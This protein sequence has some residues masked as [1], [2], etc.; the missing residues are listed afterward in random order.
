MASVP[1]NNLITFSRG[2][3]ATLTGSNG[4]IQYAPNNFV[5]F[6]EQFDNAAW[7]KNSS[8]IATNS[9]TAPDGTRTAD[10]WTPTSNGIASSVRL[11]GT[12]TL[13]VGPTATT[14]IYV[15]SAGKRWVYM[16]T[17]AASSA[18]HN[19]WF[20]LQTGTVGT[21]GSAVLAATM[22]AVGDGWYRIST[23]SLTTAATNYVFLSA[24]DA[25]NS[26]TVVADGTGI[27]IWGAQLELGSAATTY[28]STTVKNLL[29]FSEAFDNAAWNK[30]NA[31]IV[32]GAQANPVNGAFN[33]QKLMEN[34]TAG[35]HYAL[36][37]VSV[38]AAP[39]ALSVYAKAGERSFA[40]LAFD[41]LNAWFNLSTGA[42]GTV[43]AGLTASIVSVGSGWYRCSVFRT[44]AV[45]GSKSCV[46]YPA[47]ANGVVSYT[48][49]GNSGIYIYGAQLSDSASLDP[50]VPTPAAAPSSTAYYGPRFD[51][52]PVTLAPKGLLVEEAR[53]N[54]AL[55]S[56]QFDNVYWQ[57]LRGTLT[58]NATNAP[59]GVVSADRFT[60]DATTNTRSTATSAITIVSGTTY[61]ASCYLKNIDRRFVS[62]LL[63]DQATGLNGFLATFDLQ[64]GTA[65]TQLRGTGTVA[66][67]SITAAKDGWYR[68]SV[69]GTAPTTTALLM[70]SP[71]TTATPTQSS[72]GRE[73][74]LGDGVKSFFLWGAQLEAGAFATS[75]I[76]T[77]A[78]TVTRSADVATINGSLF[79]Q[80]YGQSEGS[81]AVNTSPIAVD[82]DIVFSVS[83]SGGYNNSIYFPADSGAQFIVVNGG[84]VQANIDAGTVT[85]NITNK[86][87][88]AYKASNFAASVG[89][90]AVVATTS[91]T[92]PT[93]DRAV[94]GGLEV[95][96]ANR[97]NGHIRSIDYIPTRI[98]D[99]QLQA[100]TA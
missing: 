20:D 25:D 92:I 33:A 15:K 69:T 38:L 84:A 96:T 51:Y 13:P 88:G 67:A 26:L 19:C 81:F 80:W 39:Y 16:T 21:Q 75:Y 32:T 79:S 54:L 86:I 56:E 12:F 17:P 57:T 68:C 4:L 55:Y 8:S 99:F 58:A 77:V 94:I 41:G 7:A 44:V 14:S 74:Y 76:P 11:L 62:I 87:A 64:N 23:T 29:G 47:S 61:A 59:D 52:D 22:T 63:M 31:S 85:A 83:N 24:T 90:G 36:Q 60:E 66:S 48:G 3:N 37:A 73:S 71:A 93:V 1:F 9:T 10:T 97:F 65:T 53:T 6:S 34:T 78:S 28:N 100:L 95:N 18:L 2:S 89:G 82:N 43:E 5:T 30:N 91:G 49:D 35:T 70:I 42:L 72:Y 40:S 46:V 50:Y 27:F 98:A 45:A